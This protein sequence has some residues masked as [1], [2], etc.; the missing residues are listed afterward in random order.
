M[1]G[2]NW[3][4]LDLGE[5]PVRGD[6]GAVRD[7]ANASQ[8]AARRWEKHVQAL[9]S[10]ANEGNAMEMEG[11]FAAPARRVLQS[12]PNIATPLARERSNVGQA[13]L[14]YGGQLEQ[15]K[16]ESQAALQQGTQAKRNRDTAER[17]LKQVQAQLKQ[18]QAQMRAMSATTYPAGPA[19][20]AALQRFNML[21][22]QEAQLLAQEAQCLN[23]WEMAEAQR[24][25]ARQR[26]VAAGER[27]KQ[28]EGDAARRV[29]DAMEK[30]DKL[31]AAALGPKSG[32]D[33]AS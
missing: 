33:L 4:V 23:A 8:Q 15:A 24:M 5:D 6:P 20:A 29:M 10:L 11:D 2:G 17:N 1:N 9:R 3:S 28:Q 27:A 26:A 16:R 18:V 7:L 22:A 25:A 31:I 19:Y 14:A 12:H 21:R 30:L 13:L 32:Y